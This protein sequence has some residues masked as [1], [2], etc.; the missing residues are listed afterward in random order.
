MFKGFNIKYPEYEVILPQTH[1]SFNVRTLNVQEEEKLKGSLITPLRVTEHLDK[2]IYESITKK[3]D[4]I[5]DFNTF[6]QLVTIKDR[7]AL[8]YG[9]FHITYEEVRNYN[10]TCGKCEKEYPVTIQISNIFSAKKYPGNDVLKKKEKVDLPI[11]KGVSAIIRQPTLADELSSI[12]EFGSMVGSNLD[13]ITETLVIDSFQQDITEQVEPV[14]YSDR[15]DIIDAYL[16]L[17]SKDKR[18]I[19]KKYLDT[20]GQYGISLKMK[21]YCPHCGF[22][23]D[24]DI[25]LVTNF[26]RNVYSV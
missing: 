8:L 4:S 23:E 15:Q 12:R 1:M 25:D 19:H 14:V 10:V 18:E 3:P 26:F 20:F 13:S 2:C 22:E 24:V 21:S 17:P 11:S 7:E 16:S 9:L 5:K 6:L